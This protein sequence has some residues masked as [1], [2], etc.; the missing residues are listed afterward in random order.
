MKLF[1]EACGDAHVKAILAT[2]E[3]GTLRNVA[4]A[5]LIMMAGADFIKT[6]TGKRALTRPCPFLW[7]VRAI[8]EFYE[9]TGYK[10]GYKPA[11]GI[12]KAKD[13]LV[14]L[15]MMKEELGVEWTRP[16]L[17][18]FGASSL[19]GDIE[20]Q[21]EHF[22]TGAYSN[23]LDTQWGDQMDI[24]EIYETMDYGTA[25]ES[26]EEANAWLDKNNR[27]FGHFIDGEFVSGTG[28]FETINPATG[29][30]LAHVSQAS[31]ADLDSAVAAAN[32]AFN[33]WSTRSGF[34]RAKV[35]Y[36]LARNIQKHARLFSVL[37]TLI[38]ANLFGNRV[39]LISRLSRTLLLSR[40]YG[41]ADVQRAAKSR[42]HWRLW[43]NYSAGTFRCLCWRGKS[44]RACHGQYSCF[45]TCKP[46]RL[47][48]VIRR[49]LCAIR[50]TKG[51]CK[52]RNRGW[53]CWR[54][55]RTSQRRTQIAFTGST[56]V[57]RKI[58]QATAGSGKS[59]TL[60]LGGKSPFIVFDDADLDSAAEGVVDAIWFNQG[61]V[62]CAGS[63]YWFRQVSRINFIPNL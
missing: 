33:E 24:K 46:H 6:S 43:T 39:I 50:C 28:Q 23:H 45:E 4:R 17:F 62:C 51:R 47:L 9:Q 30:S 8:R 12:S 34:E 25:P 57:G 42:S 48:P 32:H 26:A 5:S 37:E 60:E 49:N 55:D 16:E 3:L 14:Y 27:V 59:L 41:A 18:R 38:M 63:D 19:L 20:R 36:A 53:R 35:L 56:D 31:S 15:S 22:A 7:S 11:G 21:L 2:G 29:K 40:R 1:R 58:R 44:H 52:Y 54:H 13:A 61:Q 10:V